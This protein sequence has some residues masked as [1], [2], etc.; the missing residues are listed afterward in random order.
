MEVEV[1]GG[2]RRLR[3]LGYWW[4]RILWGIEEPVGEGRL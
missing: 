2:L 4:L 3:G 1:V